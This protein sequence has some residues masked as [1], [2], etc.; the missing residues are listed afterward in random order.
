[1]L[2]ISAVVEN[3]VYENPLLFDAIGEDIVNFRQVAKNILSQVEARTL[4]TVSV[5]TETVVIEESPF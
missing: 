4:K 1:M 3:I 5:E 2:K